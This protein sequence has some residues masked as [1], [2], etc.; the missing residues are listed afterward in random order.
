MNLK[1]RSEETID[2]MNQSSK[3]MFVWSAA[4]VLGLLCIT[5]GQGV[6]AQDQAVL[7]PSKAAVQQAQLLSQVTEILEKRC[8]ECHGAE[9]ARPK[10]DFGYVTD[11]A[12]MAKNPDLVTPGDPDKSELFVIIDLGDMPPAK[13]KFAPMPAEEIKA[14]HDW[15]KQGAFAIRQPPSSDAVAA[16]EL[17]SESTSS[18]TSSYRPRQP[19]YFLIGKIHPIVVHFPIA[20]IIAAGLAELCSLTQR[21]TGMTSAVTF[22]LLLGTAGAVLSAISGWVFAMEHGYAIE[23]TTQTAS[24]H[25]WLGVTSALTSPVLLWIDL[26]SNKDRRLFRVFLAIVVGLVM[27]TGHFGGM[28]V[29]GESLFSL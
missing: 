23:L 17:S 4:M 28:L 26:L 13:S 2:T 8:A 19:I 27:A 9:N 1:D 20:L 16:S 12:R 22:C 25:R 10:G 24:L 14:V 29:Y 21:R 5:W 3:R 7:S 15:I 18:E 6:N 11:L